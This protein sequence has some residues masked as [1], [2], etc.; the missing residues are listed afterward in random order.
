MGCLLLQE[1]S[2][3]EPH[4]TLSFQALVIAQIIHLPHPG[5]VCLFFGFK[6]TARRHN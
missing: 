6:G 5:R 3:P 4:R 1:Q 2:C